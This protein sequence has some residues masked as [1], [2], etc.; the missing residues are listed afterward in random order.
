V[1]EDLA[2]WCVGRQRLWDEEWNF[3]L[4][5]S[6]CR[7]DPTDWIL[8]RR[9]KCGWIARVALGW[10]EQR[11]CSASG[12]GLRQRG[13]GVMSLSRFRL[14]ESSQRRSGF[15]LLNYRQRH[16]IFQRAWHSLH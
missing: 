3:R 12:E 14:W 5:Q 6:P 10:P 16:D 2:C 1:E 7:Q 9:R 15:R 11:T 4:K 13:I 8:G